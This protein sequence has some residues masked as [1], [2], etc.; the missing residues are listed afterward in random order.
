MG[1]NCNDGE[2]RE[3][4]SI[5]SRTWLWRG[6]PTQHVRIELLPGRERRRGRTADEVV[7]RTLMKGSSSALHKAIVPP[8]ALFVIKGR[9][10]QSISSLFKWNEY[11][12]WNIEKEA[13]MSQWKIWG[14]E[15]NTKTGENW[16][17]KYNRLRQFRLQPSMF[18]VIIG[19]VASE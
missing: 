15:R 11:L 13:T 9:S 4:R 16:S 3:L 12:G 17:T 19:R 7:G 6:H 2:N 18:Q 8:D 10:G 1:N 5:T 14:S